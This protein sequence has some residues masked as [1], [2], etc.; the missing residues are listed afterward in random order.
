LTVPA[1]N[2]IPSSIPTAPF[3]LLDPDLAWPV[4]RGLLSALSSGELT[5][6]ELSR[7]R[8]RLDRSLHPP[9]ATS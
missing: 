1:T 2:A 9:L 6:N 3:D 5:A 4:L 8:A 7:S